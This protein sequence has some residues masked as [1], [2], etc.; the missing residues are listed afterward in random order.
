MAE[1]KKEKS[2][3]EEK[4]DAAGAASKAEL[5]GTKKIMVMAGIIGGMMLVLSIIS[6]TVIMKLKPVDPEVLAEKVKQ[7][8]E[9]EEREK[10]TEMGAVMKSPIEVV[11]NLAG[12]EGDRFL[13]AA[14]VLEYEAPKEGGGE[15]EGGGHGGGGGGG[16][17]EI[18]KRLP[19]LKDIAID[20]LSSKTYEEIKD[21]EDRRKILIML[22]NEMNK[23]FPEPEK[24]KNIYFD[25][26]IVQ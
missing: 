15:G 20:L 4:K 14:L 16:D 7:Q 2:E 23:T 26:F 13:K 21:R 18:T 25:S 22:K 19:K 11:V 9:E 6:Y 24:I 3:K 12:G 1:E 8:K 5:A 17:P 10:Q